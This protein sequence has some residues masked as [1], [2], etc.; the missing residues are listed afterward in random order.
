MKNRAEAVNTFHPAYAPSVSYALGALALGFGGN[1]CAGIVST[2]MAAYL[3]NAIFDLLGTQDS[4]RVSYTGSYINSTYIVGWALGGIFFGWIGDRFGRV[5]TLAISLL[6]IALFTLSVERVSSWYFLV[7]LRFL[8]GIGS[9]ATMVLSA[10]FVAEVWGHKAK[11][12]AIAIG[13]LAVGFPIGIISSGLVTHIAQGWRTAFFL[14]GFPPLILS[15][16]CFFLLKE[17][18]QWSLI[19]ED[20][21]SGAASRSQGALQILLNRQNRT[22]FFIA[23][24]IFGAMLVGIW[25]TFSW[26]PTWAQSL[27]GSGL[28]QGGNLIALLGAGGILGSLLSGFLANSMGRQGTLMLAFGGAS[29]ASFI[30]YFTNTEFGSV[31][32]VQTAFL[33]LFYGVSQAVFSAYI[34]ELFPASVRST[35]TGISFNAGRLVTA[36]A[37]FFVGVLVPALGGYGNSLLVFSLTY[38]IGFIAVCFGKETKGSV[39]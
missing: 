27:G 12:R 15:L 1:L 20:D 25:S 29:I 5:R 37:V 23:A 17:P 30:L 10:V 19:R 33:A 22:N 28:R 21:D 8:A 26:L 31:V 34:P 4:T 13:V 11:G 2:L 35:A 39:L 9:G 36:L 24:T 16:I 38:I 32:Y 7:F 6:I 3:P 18:V 14:T